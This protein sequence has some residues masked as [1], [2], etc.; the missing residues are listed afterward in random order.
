MRH[1][2]PALFV[3]IALAAAAHAETVRSEGVGTAPLPG[4][5]GAA[6]RSAA[7]AAALE[8]AVQRVAA[9][10]AGSAPS[11]AAAAALREALGPD[12]ARFAVSYRGLSE[13]ERNRP[14]ASGRELAVSVEAVVDRGLVAEALRRAG[15]LAAQAEVPPADAARRIVL[16]PVPSWRAL[17]ALRQRLVE[18]GARR[19][20][21]ERVEPTRAVL[22]VEAERGAASLLRA[23]LQ[24]PPP[25][26]SIEAN[27][28]QDG[29][30]RIRL[31][32]LAIGRSAD[33]GAIDTP[34][35]K[36]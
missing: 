30:P 34:A 22:D 2:L 28:E 27:G 15:L 19:V 18:L 12:P 20:T 35:A 25:G 5:A 9:G 21:L 16:E 4:A 24:D 32:E 10:L 1:A 14:D 6:P 31:H 33:P 8:D 13:V 29:A 23:A 17:I 11:P 7:L 36:R 3:A 26:I